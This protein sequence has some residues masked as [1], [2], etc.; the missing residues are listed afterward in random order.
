[1][2]ATGNHAN[3]DART[4][5]VCDVTFELSRVR[6]IKIERGD[7]E[8][9]RLDGEPFSCRLS[10]D[11]AERE[12]ADRLE[13]LWRQNLGIFRRVEGGCTLLLLHGLVGLWD[14]DKGGP[15]MPPSSTGPVPAHSAGAMPPYL[16][17]RFNDNTEVD[18]VFSNANEKRLV[19]REIENM[20]GG[21][22]DEL[23]RAAGFMG[24]QPRQFFA[25]AAIILLTALATIVFLILHP[26]V[27]DEGP[28]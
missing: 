8:V 22:Q 17:A 3:D 5:V 19:A 25:Y 14:V 7:V 21:N 6:R 2:T 15:S 28:R 18:L 23:R 4:I 26:V 1:M 13:S 9:Y 20:V 24:R 11:A 12:L 10:D 27:D 16:V